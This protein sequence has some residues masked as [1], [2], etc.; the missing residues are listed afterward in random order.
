V[1]LGLAAGGAW[2]YRAHAGQRRLDE[3]R[4]LVGTRPADAALEDL[5]RRYPDRPEVFLLSARQARLAGR[6]T[7]AW[8]H[9]ERFTALG[10]SAAEAER[11]RT[12]GRPPADF[13]VVRP[14]L[15][16]LLGPDPGDPDV[17]LALADGELQAGHADAAAAL[18]DRAVRQAPADPRALAVRGEAWLRARRL[19][20]ARA[21]LTAATGAGPDALAY[22]RARLALATCLID[23]G[24]F[25]PAR[26]LCLAARRDNPDDLVA[27]FGVG[28][29]AS[30]LGRLDEA[31]EAFAAVLAV[32][33]THAETL[34]SLA[35]VVEQQGDLPRA[36]EY[37]E[38]A[39][40]AD[41][42]RR[43]TQAALARLYA[44][45]GR[46]DRAAA[47]EARYRATDPAAVT[48]G[49]P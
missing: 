7:D 26:E 15:E 3:A 45:L 25:G 24:E 27:A 40:R 30:F 39:E 28:R 4:A 44:A 29:T 22:P 17:L 31:R 48:G 13:P 21:D 6:P 33:P 12:L 16:R 5:R 34:V 35:H 2:W 18:A 46:D 8:E 36:V 23:L 38:R 19:D 10:G 32:R 42:R 14:A 20:L 43:E 37:L 9:L 41:P 11:E 49:K 47:H 1:L